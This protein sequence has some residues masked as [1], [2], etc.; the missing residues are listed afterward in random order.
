[1]TPTPVSMEARLCLTVQVQEHRDGEAVR[2]VAER[3]Q[4]LRLPS[5]SRGYRR[6]SA[7]HHGSRGRCTV[8]DADVTVGGITGLYCLGGEGAVIIEPQTI[9]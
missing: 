2:W 7:L 6:R 5:P 4:Y 3:L 1:M 9:S 8:Y